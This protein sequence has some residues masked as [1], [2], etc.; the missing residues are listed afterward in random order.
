MQ[1]TCGTH[2]HTVTAF[3]VIHH[4]TGADTDG[5]G[6]ILV[7]LPAQLASWELIVLL[8]CPGAHVRQ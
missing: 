7:R 6:L 5:D 4:D 3:D 8:A 2:Q 1:T